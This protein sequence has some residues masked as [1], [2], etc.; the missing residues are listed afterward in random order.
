MI[1]L[2][3]NAVNVLKFKKSAVTVLYVYGLLLVFYLPSL[4]AMVLEAING[5]TPSARMAYEYATTVVS[6]N[7]PINPIIYCWRIKLV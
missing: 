1:N 7:S 4:V 5:P 2:Q 6:I 3:H